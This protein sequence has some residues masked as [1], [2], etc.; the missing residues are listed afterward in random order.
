MGF[1]ELVGSLTGL[2]IVHSS[3]KKPSVTRIRRVTTG[4]T[5]TSL[6]HLAFI[7]SFQVTNLVVD[8]HSPDTDN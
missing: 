8:R 7:G 4:E 6:H 2:V 5:I 3:S 1:G